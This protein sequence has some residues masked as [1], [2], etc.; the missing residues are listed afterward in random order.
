MCDDDHNGGS[1]LRKSLTSPQI[2][3]YHRDCPD[4]I[5]AAWA[6]KKRWRSAFLIGLDAGNLPHSNVN[7]KGQKIVFVDLCPNSVEGLMEIIQKSK[8]TWIID[9]HETTRYTLDALI[10]KSSSDI[11]S[12]LHIIFDLSLA[13]CQLAWD[14]CFESSFDSNRPWFIEYIADADLWTWTQLKSKEVNAALIEDG[15]VNFKGL[16]HLFGME[17]SS[18]FIERL[19]ERGEVVTKSHRKEIDA[20]INAAVPA[21]FLGKYKIWVSTVRRQY[22]SIVGNELANKPFPVKEG[23]SETTNLPAFAALWWW[24]YTELSWQI[25]LRGPDLQTEDTPNLAEITSKLYKGGGHATAAGFTIA[26]PE[27]FN[28]YFALDKG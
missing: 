27:H 23:E 3:F 22:R 18:K 5:S 26:Q 12:K 7:I 19:V 24:S 16:D 15:W 1:T 25:S 20:A 4:G 17:N 2:V 8:E 11:I 6:I 13:G 28:Q 10:A 9:H 14:T 21:L